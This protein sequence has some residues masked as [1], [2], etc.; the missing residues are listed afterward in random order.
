MLR[1]RRGVVNYVWV[2]EYQSTGRPHYHF[3]AD[4]PRL[5]VI[6]LSHYWNS[7]F[8][9]A[10][11]RGNSIR[12]GTAPP[13]RKMFVDSPTMARYLTKYMGKG[14]GKNEPDSQRQLHTFGHSQE[15]W[16]K[17]RPVTYEATY[18]EQKET[19]YDVFGKFNDTKY[20]IGDAVQVI[21]DIQR[22]FTLCENSANEL[23]EV[24]GNVPDEY[25]VFDDTQYSWICPNPL[26]RVYYGI[27]KPMQKVNRK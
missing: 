23:V 20:R 8:D 5:D 13:D 6:H 7:L 11:D 4:A 1:A 22:S 19:R 27:P 2:R 15:C 17:S 18:I 26:H 3:V 24:Y 25:K 14:F 9:G 10:V 16:Q 12:L 21:T